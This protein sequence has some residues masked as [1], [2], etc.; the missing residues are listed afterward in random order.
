MFVA[1]EVL[2][3]VQY[4]A[5]RG[6]LARLIRAGLLSPSQ[7]AY[8]HGTVGLDRASAGGLSKLV[9]VQVSELALAGETNGVAIRWQASGPGSGLFPVLDADIVLAP[10]DDRHTLLTLTGVYRPPLGPLGS[11]LDRAVLHRV[12]AATIRNFL[13]RLAADISHGNGRAEAAAAGT[14][15]S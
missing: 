10:A 9:T 5:A 2:L 15:P 12:A 13:G 8:D 7:D 6:R 1:D 11:L 4:A 3:D 14:G